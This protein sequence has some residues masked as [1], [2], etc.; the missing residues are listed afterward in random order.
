MAASDGSTGG[1]LPRDRCRR[2]EQP[3][4]VSLV[5]FCHRA[6]ITNIFNEVLTVFGACGGAAPGAFTKRYDLVPISA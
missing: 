3:N 5:Q 4:N 6:V 2:D 1:M